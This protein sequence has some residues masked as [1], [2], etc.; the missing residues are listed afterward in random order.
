MPV[1]ESVETQ[2]SVRSWVGKLA[3]P[4]AFCALLGVMLLP[5]KGLSSYGQIVLAV[6]VMAVILWVTEALAYPVS[7]FLIAGMLALLIGLI[8]NSETG[9]V[10][11]TSKA[12]VLTMKGFASSGIVM[13]SGAMIMAAAM[14]AT[15]LDQRVAQGVLSRVKP[16]TSAI[17]AGCMLIG[18]LLAFM[19]PSP[20][21]RTAVQVPILAGVVA[22]LGL[23]EK[24]RLAAVLVI[25]AAQVA[26]LWNVGVMTA[27]V[28]NIIGLELMA[29]HS[30]FSITWGQWLLHAAPWSAVMTVILF[31]ILRREMKGHELPQNVSATLA[32][33]AKPWTL[34]QKKLAIYTALLLLLWITEGG[35]HH[36]SVSASML[37]MSVILIMPDIG[38]FDSWK[39]VEHRIHWGVLI[40]FGISISLGQQLVSTGAAAW[41]ASKCFSSLDLQA[42]SLVMLVVIMTTFTT[43]MHLGF[44]SAASLTVALLP[45]FLAFADTLPDCMMSNGISLVL[46]QLYAVSFGMILPVNSPQNMVAFSTDTFS[47]RSFARIGIILTIIS[48]A[49]FGL[50]AMTWWQWTGLLSG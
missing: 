3:I 17:L 49:T 1:S 12:L 40:M 11:G 18:I 50:F 13:I 24:S 33:K 28:H 48:L 31:F 34:K 4:L 43:V 9:E 39:D 27:T 35:L 46:L 44:A 23:K 8:P 29:D 42:L 47:A 22:A 41:L 38:V 6:L 36:V 21:G 15:G 7:A 26:T 45:V 37:I 30:G 2:Q 32:G 14:Q 20:T 25:G 16:N 19:V 10:L 5:L